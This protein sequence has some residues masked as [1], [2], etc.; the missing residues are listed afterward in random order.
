LNTVKSG[1][2]FDARRSLRHDETL[3][4]RKVSLSL[5]QSSTLTIERQSDDKEFSR[6]VEGMRTRRLFSGATPNNDSP[7][8]IAAPVL[9]STSDGIS[10]LAAG[11][12]AMHQLDL[13]PVLNDSNS[14]PPPLSDDVFSSKSSPL[15]SLPPTPLHPNY[16]STPLRPSDNPSI[17]S[18]TP[19]DH[20]AR[21]Q[22]L[23]AEESEGEG[24]V[25]QSISGR[26][27]TRKTESRAERP[28]RGRQSS[29]SKEQHAESDPA[30]GSTSISTKTAEASSSR[31]KSFTGQ[32]NIASTRRVMTGT[33]IVD[34]QEL[35]DAIRD[36][37]AETRIELEPEATGSGEVAFEEAGVIV[38]VNRAREKG[39]GRA[40]APRKSK[41]KAK[42]KGTGKMTEEDSIMEESRISSS[43]TAVAFQTDLES[44][45]SALSTRDAPELS[46]LLVS[47]SKSIGLVDYDSTP[48]SASI[49]YPDSLAVSPGAS[50]QP[51]YSPLSVPALA[52][53]DFPAAMEEE[54][55]IPSSSLSIITEPPIDLHST[56]PTATTWIRTED[57]IMTIPARD[58]DDQGR[59]DTPI[60]TSFA[61]STLLKS[62]STLPSLSHV[63]EVGEEEDQVK[64]GELDDEMM[65]DSTS[66]AALPL[67]SL[68]PTVPPAVP[69]KHESILEAK[70]A[71]S[72]EMTVNE[73]PS[74][75]SKP[76][77]ASD[78]VVIEEKF[79]VV[80][81]SGDA[82]EAVAREQ[83][84]VDK[85]EVDEAAEVSFRFLRLPLL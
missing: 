54:L 4:V 66:E 45:A 51:S 1:K 70:E 43:P 15:S 5:F 42:G 37:S 68:R 84:F 79:D 36:S 38:D 53:S 56:T 75:S 63:A 39:K 50:T 24:V 41:G 8:S 46:T 69:H 62:K 10:T 73:P 67:A 85:M 40:K 22:A 57:A 11:S 60:V 77:D 64:E 19:L 9:P 28:V 20:A 12:S 65:I 61:S 2:T 16:V 23:Q 80:E 7:P 74:D 27:A 76:R 33:G 35:E 44:T 71:V 48:A 14:P 78:L 29:T 31:R 58:D 72:I 6:V 49:S 30:Q 82:R 21:L 25:V 26:S 3:A 47:P 34:A 18:P 81:M 83:E 13:V 17:S 55:I 32:K 59:I 52:Q